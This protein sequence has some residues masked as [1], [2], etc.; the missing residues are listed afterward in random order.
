V[1]LHQ[2]DAWRPSLATLPGI[3]VQYY[4]YFQILAGWFFTTLAV[5]ALTGLVRSD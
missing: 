3:F 1:N 4:F 5:A 2:E